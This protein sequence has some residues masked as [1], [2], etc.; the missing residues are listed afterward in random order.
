M[1]AL[2][3]LPSNRSDVVAATP[4]GHRWLL[5]NVVFESLWN[6]G[7]REGLKILSA[8]GINCLRVRY[9]NTTHTFHP[10]RGGDS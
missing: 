6:Y 10:A 7:L 4:G 1:S 8:L 9:E 2:R 5:G 3:F